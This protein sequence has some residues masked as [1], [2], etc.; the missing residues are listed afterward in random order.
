MIL[1]ALATLGKSGKRRGVSRRQIVQTVFR[2]DQRMP[3]T[4][5]AKEL[6]HFHTHNIGHQTAKN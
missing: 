2:K 5:K 6:A 3:L 4:C 1:R